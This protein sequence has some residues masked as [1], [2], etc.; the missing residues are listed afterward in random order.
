MNS[1]HP[2]LLRLPQTA[3]MGYN[4]LR[5]KKSNLASATGASCGGNSGRDIGVDASEFGEKA[6]L[7]TKAEPEVDR[8]ALSCA[9]S[10]VTSPNSRRYF[11]LDDDDA[12][13]VLTY[14]ARSLDDLDVD[15]FPSRAK[16][17]LG[18][19]AYSVSDCE[20]VESDCDELEP[21]YDDIDNPFS[22]AGSKSTTF[23]LRA[24]TPTPT[25]SC[26]LD[27]PSRRARARKLEKLTRHLGEKVPSELVFGQV[28]APKR[29][30][31]GLKRSATGRTVSSVASFAPSAV[32]TFAD[33]PFSASHATTTT[34]TTSYV[35]SAVATAATSK[36][37]KQARRT[38]VSIGIC[39][40]PPS[41]HALSVYGS[42]TASTYGKK[43][44]AMRMRAIHAS[45]KG[46][47]KAVVGRDVEEWDA[48]EYQDVVKR[49]RALKA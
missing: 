5:A 35:T 18:S 38:S 44:G 12:D 2:P 30:F 13:S 31:L 25:R 40:P 7:P 9:L 15:C 11:K 24:P 39:G 17:R 33:D 8:D 21:E 16:S 10:T 28:N 20:D 46:A 48:A 27:G 47:G 19:Y 43:S 49:L 41:S 42:S 45:S 29:G 26:S 34:T 36:A 3:R 37:T 14:P 4:T 6:R 23:D 1:P 22:P 32:S